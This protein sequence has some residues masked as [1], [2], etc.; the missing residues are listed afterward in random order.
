V[1][2]LHLIRH[3]RASASADDYDQLQPLGETQA[4]LLGEHLGASGQ[5]YDRVYV[6]PL[7][8]QRDTLRLM[9]EA[10]GEA[11]AGWPQEIELVGLREAPFDV[12]LKQHLMPRL[13]HDATLRE[14]VETL[15]QATERSAR[16]AAMA[17]VFGHMLRLWVQG[18][19]GSELLPYADFR[20]DVIGAYDTIVAGAAPDQHVAVVTSNGVIGVMLEHA[21]NLRPAPDEGMA[22]LANS[23][24]SVLEL[25]EQ[26]A[27]LRVHGGIEHLKEPELVTVL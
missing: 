27:S 3:G 11:G 8:R 6:G 12:L 20:R 21:V 13:E 15:Q 19:V 7:K 25:G 4:R 22:M 2:R 5:R 18:E 14:R 23:S 9:R 10:A 24:V 26:G 1:I 16:H 17:K